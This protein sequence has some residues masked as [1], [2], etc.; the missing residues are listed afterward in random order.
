MNLSRVKKIKPKYNFSIKLQ[1][2]IIHISWECLI[3]GIYQSCKHTFINLQ[4]MQHWKPPENKPSDVFY[5][6]LQRKCQAF[7]E[8]IEQNRAAGFLCICWDLWENKESDELFNAAPSLCWLKL[9]AFHIPHPS[10]H[11]YEGIESTT[12]YSWNHELEELSAH[13]SS[14]SHNTYTHTTQHTLYS[15]HSLSTHVVTPSTEED[16]CYVSAK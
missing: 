11:R 15:R 4:K 16:G 13:T 8:T 9:V 10:V 5:G 12:K 7:S 6:R 14:R 3:C 1:N 2:L